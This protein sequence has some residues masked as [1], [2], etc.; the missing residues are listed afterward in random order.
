MN[1]LEK[2]IEEQKNEIEE[3]KNEIEE[4]RSLI[5]DLT[6]RF[7]RFAEPCAIGSEQLWEVV[8]N[9]ILK[10]PVPAGVNLKDLI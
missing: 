6:Y 1:E 5:E 8:F 9:D 2:Q 3:Q 4:L 10:R 7:E